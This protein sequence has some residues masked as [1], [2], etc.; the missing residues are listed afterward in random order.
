MRFETKCNYIG[1]K[2]KVSEKGN[3]YL[4][5]SFLDDD[6]IFNAVSDVEVPENIERLDEVNVEFE[7]T[8]KYNNLRVKRIWK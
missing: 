5:I 7:L 2:K 3:E 6:Y 1:K 8:V 4:L